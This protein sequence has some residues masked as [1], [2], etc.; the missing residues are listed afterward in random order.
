MT[1]LVWNVRVMVF[2]AALFASLSTF[3]QGTAFTYQGRLDVNGAPANGLYDF[4]FTVRDMPLAG[5]GLG[6]FP[7]SATLPVSNGLFT[8]TLDPGPG[9]FTGPAR[10]LEI[11]VRSNG[12]GAF[13]DVTPRQLIT[14]APYSV[15]AAIAGVASGVTPGSINSAALADGSV[16]TAKLAP[17]AVNALSNPS[18]TIS[19]AV[20]VWRQ[21]QSARRWSCRRASS[22]PSTRAAR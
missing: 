21:T 9:V 10:W 19:N 16:T 2:V 8:V 17:G 1:A 18:G 14:S 5:N 11:N 6:M 22:R 3:A 4:R 15:R 12:A 13:V 20:L 7:L